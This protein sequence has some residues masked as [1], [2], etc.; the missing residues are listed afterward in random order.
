MVN[1]D[2]PSAQLVRRR[3]A[4]GTVSRDSDSFD[5]EWFL[6]GD[7]HLD[8]HALARKYD[9][10]FHPESELYRVRN[11]SLSPAGEVAGKVQSIATVTY[12]RRTAISQPEETGKPVFSF[13]AGGGTKHISRAPLVK[14]F[15]GPQNN[16]QTP[17]PGDLVGWNGDTTM[18][19]FQV[20]G[21]DVP[22]ASI[23]ESWER[24]MRMSELTT[25]WR[26][27]IAKMIGTCNAATFK[28]WERGEALL[29]DCN[30]SGTADSSEV[31]RVR[32][33]F[34]IKINEKDAEVGGIGIGDVEGWQYVWS[35]AKPS[36]GENG[37]ESHWVGVSK[38]VEY[39]DFKALGV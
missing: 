19:G 37:P 29:V 23:K 11:I 26:R 17:A 39:S 31:V 7:S 21:V 25:A 4:A 32:F 5:E 9:R 38:V 15:K 24:E 18:Q 33:D 27:K 35:I 8:I 20:A 2:N 30:L 22:T 36:G 34:A 6:V 12:S 10:T 14:L 16:S 3:M 28:G 13:T 1:F